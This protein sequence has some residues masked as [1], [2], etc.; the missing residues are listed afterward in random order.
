VSG[1]APSGT[2]AVSGSLCFGGVKA[3][4]RAESRVGGLDGQ[5]CRMLSAITNARA[6]SA[7]AKERA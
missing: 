7:D 3:C 5:N 4:R 2:L 1:D 6:K